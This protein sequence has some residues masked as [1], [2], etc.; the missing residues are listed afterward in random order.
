MTN[1]DT[2]PQAVASD[3]T[4][5]LICRRSSTRVFA[6]TPVDEAQRQAV[7]HAATRAPSGGAMMMYSIIDIRR[8]ETIERRATRGSLR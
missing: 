2:L 8:R 4:L 1:I 7:L 3:A 5:D 6:D